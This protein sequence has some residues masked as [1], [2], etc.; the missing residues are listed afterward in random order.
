M[1]LDNKQ[2]GALGDKKYCCLVAFL[3]TLKL[4]ERAA[5]TSKI[6]NTWV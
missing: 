6:K 2:R 5:S 1:I 3:K 4:K